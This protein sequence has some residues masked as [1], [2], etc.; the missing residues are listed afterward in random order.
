MPAK[1]SSSSS[2]SSK[3]SY[4]DVSSF[5]LSEFCD[6]ADM[7]TIDRQ[8]AINKHTKSEW[9]QSEVTKVVPM[10]FLEELFSLIIFVFGV[11]GSAYSIPIVLGFIGFLTGSYLKSYILGFAILAPFAFLPAPFYPKS[12]S[13]WFSFQI[14]RYFSFKCIYAEKIEE[15]KPYIL[16]G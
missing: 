6:L 1:K 12:L 15:N 2:S 7:S 14:L 11:P 16:V 3:G 8:K 4:L 9:V 13:T 5:S 10:T